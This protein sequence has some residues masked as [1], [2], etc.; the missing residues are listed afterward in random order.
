MADGERLAEAL[1]PGHPF[2]IPGQPCRMS[3]SRNARLLLC[4]EDRGGYLPVLE[5]LQ[6]VVKMGWTGWL[7]YEIFSRTL[8]GPNPKT[9]EMHAARAS[10]S[11]SNVTAFLGQSGNKDL[12]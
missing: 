1:E 5:I 7:S 6:T 3:W 8:A 2:H 12:E 11:W 10:R 9:P 4:E